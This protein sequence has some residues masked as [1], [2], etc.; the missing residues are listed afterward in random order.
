MNVHNCLISKITAREIL[1]SRGLP[2]VEA[3]VWLRGGISAVA[4]VPSGTSTGKFEA[5]ELRDGDKNR[6]LGK[7]VTLAV[8][9][10]Q[11]IISPSLENFDV[12]NQLMIDNKLIELDATQ[13]KSQLGANA[14]LAVSLAC[15]RAGSLCHRLPLYSYLN[16]IYNG[17]K[18]A[19]PLPLMNF[20]NGGRHA[21]TNLQVQEIVIIP[22]FFNSDG[23]V[24]FSECIQA[25]AEIFSNLALLFKDHNLDTD[26]GYEGGYAPNFEGPDQAIQLL[27]EGIEKAG[28]NLGKQVVIGLDMA[29]SEFYASGLY[30][31]NNQDFT[32]DDLISLYER[33]AK[34]Y[35]LF[36]IE[37][38]L[39]QEDWL[40][41]TKMTTRL[42]K[43]I[44]LVGDD[45]FVTNKIRL[46]QGIDSQAGNAVIVKPNQI[47]TLSETVEIIKIAKRTGYKVIVSHRSGETMDTFIADLA[48]GLGA[49][50]IKAGSVARGE[51][52]VK[53]NRLLAIEQELNK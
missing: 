19:V 10:I 22:K 53:Y 48:V 34:D 9:N 51:R 52:V 7:G 3:E 16:E 40:S 32:A 31:F 35:P 36:S 17:G 1:D 6:Y 39:D 47:G 24:N 38:G 44:L 49:D 28:Y 46:Q 14:I 26:L 50:F 8:K 37:D 41:W 12:N 18:M 11:K 29:A 33:W 15:A 2:T 13:N 21:D 43:K 5:L 4:S 30:K 20:I 23:L 25:G 27:L 42:G 45:L